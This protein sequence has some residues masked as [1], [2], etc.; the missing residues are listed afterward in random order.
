MSPTGRNYCTGN[1]LFRRV[2][3][4]EIPA[5]MQSFCLSLLFIIFFI[6]QAL[7]YLADPT[8]VGSGT[9]GVDAMVDTWLSSKHLFFLSTYRIHSLC[10]SML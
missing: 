2:I 4:M 9:L 6:G 8:L 1:V 5:C 3:G 10:V 7:S